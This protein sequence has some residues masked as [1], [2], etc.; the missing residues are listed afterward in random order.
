MSTRLSAGRVR[1]IY[2]FIKSP[3]D[4]YS[5]QTMCR[6]LDVA[7]SGYYKWLKEP[8]SNRAQE[9]ARLLRLIRASFVAS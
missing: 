3:R 4:R 2:E 9:D 1:A 6:V 5:V 8:L 7:P